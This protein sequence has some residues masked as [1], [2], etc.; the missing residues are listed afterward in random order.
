M[1]VMISFS[2]NYFFFFACKIHINAIY[3][4]DIILFTHIAIN[5]RI[6]IG[7]YSIIKTVTYLNSVRG[8]DGLKEQMVFFF[9]RYI[10][11]KVNIS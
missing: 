5:E 11:F 4:T 3:D 1:Y 2:E 6:V 7:M 9:L 10:L 8:E